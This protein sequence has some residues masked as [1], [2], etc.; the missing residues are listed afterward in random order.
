[1]LIT[2]IATRFCISQKLH[3]RKTNLNITKDDPSLVFGEVKGSANIVYRLRFSLSLAHLFQEKYLAFVGLS[4]EVA[5]GSPSGIGSG[6]R[7]NEM[8]QQ[9]NDND[10][11]H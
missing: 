10:L 9:S 7:R 11:K 4:S 6:S 2:G 5:L 8:C 3:W 1:M